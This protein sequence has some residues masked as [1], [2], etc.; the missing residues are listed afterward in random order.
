M[1]AAGVLNIIGL[2]QHRSRAVRKGDTVDMD[3]IEFR[4]PGYGIAPDQ[5]ER[6][7]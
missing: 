1:N 3:A 2:G 5:M 7:A 4:R 6:V